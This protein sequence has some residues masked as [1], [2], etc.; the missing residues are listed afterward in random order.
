MRIL[1]RL[2]AACAATLLPA[3]SQDNAQVTREDLMVAP[4]DPVGDQE[5]SEPDAIESADDA[6]AADTAAASERE[7]SA[8]PRIAY[9]YDLSFTVPGGGVAEAQES[10]VALCERLGAQCQIVGMDRSSA[11]RDR[12]YGTLSLRVAAGTARA[13]IETAIA[14][15]GE[16]GGRAVD[17]SIAAED[18]SKQIVDAEARIRQR[19]LLVRRLTEILRTRSGEVGDLI[20]AERAVADA[21]EELDQ[22][23]SWHAELRGRVAYSTITMHYAAIAAGAG[24]VG[25]RMT[26]MLA[27]SGS[28]FLSGLEAFLTVAIFLLPWLIVL[29]PLG[30]L[31]LRLRRRSRRDATAEG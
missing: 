18:V 13:F 6:G 25:N 23:R 7:R 9:R 12:D 3:C 21:Q 24:G 1:P 26:D 29:V 4:A 8:L 19:S 2:I 28:I 27:R 11:E 16:S 14:S 22:A 31:L 10:H 5:A 17:R 15:V 20:A 30:W